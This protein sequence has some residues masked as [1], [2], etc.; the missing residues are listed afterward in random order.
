MAIVPKAIFVGPENIG[1]F[2]ESKIRPDWDFVAFEPD[3][4]SLW[5]D[6]NSGAVDNDV[7]IIIILNIFFNKDEYENNDESFERMIAMMAPYCFV[8]IVAYRDNIEAQIRERIDNE[9]ERLSVPQSDYY[10][11]DPK[12]PKPTLDKSIQHYIQNSEN[13]EIATILAGEELEEETTPTQ[14]LEPAKIEKNDYHPIEDETES[15]RLGQV[16]AVTSSKGGSGKSTVAISLATYLA[17]SSEN[18]VIEKIAEKPLK[19]IVVDLDVRDGQV[20]FLTGNMKPTVLHMRSQGISNMTLEQSKIHSDRL[21]VDLLLAPK[22]PRLSDDTPAEFYLELIQLLKKNYDYI[23]LDTSVNYL[24]PLLENVAY[25]IAD[26]IIFVTDI[27]VNSVYSMTRWIQEVTRPQSKQGM[28]IPINKIGIVV[29]KSIS[30]V[31]MSGQKIARS[32]LGIPV[33]TVIPNNAKLIAH[34]A[35]LQQMESVLR[36]NDI[37]IAIRRLARAIV[38]N[39]YKLSE[40]IF[41][42]K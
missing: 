12:H 7:H 20:G 5:R 8:G 39:K 15:D 35:N 18:S 34:A 3:V 37:R 41:N 14:E 6:L 10:F 22:R 23:I 1:K 9:A 40:K 38:G 13:R 2:F 19:V 26:Q 4:S 11:I 30:N 16:V 33:I 24:D 42:N 17:H 21:K 29:N 31:N 28:G 27:V 36:H 32:A 25:P